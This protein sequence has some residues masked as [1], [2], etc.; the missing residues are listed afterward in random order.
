[1]A[2]FDP[3]FAE[4]QAKLAAT[5]A[6]L[7][8]HPEIADEVRDAV[9]AVNTPIPDTRGV[10]SAMQDEARANALSTALSD[11]DAALGVTPPVAEGGDET[12]VE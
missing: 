11:F 8:N 3:V 5:L 4:L 10:A 7:E 2:K 6:V 1:M 9:Q 12:E